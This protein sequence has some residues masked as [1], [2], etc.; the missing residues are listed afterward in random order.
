M[1]GKVT[2]NVEKHAAGLGLDDGEG[3][4]QHQLCLPLTQA[5]SLTLLAEATAADSDINTFHVASPL[6]MFLED[7][8]TPDQL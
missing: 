2:N 4:G 3:L 5:S 7:P 8:I 1:S 6:A